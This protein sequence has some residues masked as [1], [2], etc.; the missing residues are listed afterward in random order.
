MRYYEIHRHDEFSLF[1]GFGNSKQATKYSKELGHKLLGLTNHGNIV[2]L[3]KHFKS[4]VDNDI[5]PILGCEF[6]FQPKIDKEEP[7]YHLC[8]FAKNLEGWENLCTLITISNQDDHFY[9]Q[10]RICFEDLEKYSKGLIVST[11]CISGYIP[12]LLSAGNEE[13]AYEELIKFKKIFKNDSDFYFEVQPILINDETQNKNG[14]DIQIYVNNELFKLRKKYMRNNKNKNIPVIVTTDAHF[15]SKEQFKSYLKMHEIK[16]TNIGEHYKERYIHSDIEIE[17]KLKK[18]HNNE[19]STIDNG[20]RLFQQTI[21]DTKEWFK[22]DLEI[23]QYRINKKFDNAFDELKYKCIKGLKEKGKTSKKY[24]ERLKH[25]LSVI[26][27][28]GF[29]DYFLIVAEYVNWAKENDIAV[30]PGRGSAGNSIITYALDITEVDAIYFNNNFDRFMRY[31]KKKFP[32]VDVDFCQTRRNEVINHILERYKNRSSQTLT[33]GYYNIKNLM[34]DL[35]KVCG[36]DDKAT[37]E[38]IKKEL[39]KY[40]DDNE[41]IINEEIDSNKYLSTVNEEYDNII[42]HFKNMYGKVR[43]FGTHASSVIVSNE[44]ISKKCG[45]M[46]IGSNIRTSFDLKDIE[47]LGL[48]KLDILG[49]SSASKAHELEKLTG[50]SFSY[51]MLNDYDTLK[52]FEKGN[53]SVFQFE[54]KSAND[55]AQEIGI[56]SFEDVI[57]ATSVNRPGP[58][59]LGMH[60][61]YKNNKLNPDKS[62]PIYE[63]TKETYGTLIYQEQGMPICREIGNLDWTITDKIVKADINHISKENLEEWKKAFIKGAKEYGLTKQQTKEIFTSLVQYSFNRGHGVAYSMLS[64]ELMYFKVHYPL[65]FWFCTMKY[66]NKDD[67]LIKHE[68]Q[69]AKEGII[70]LLPHVNGKSDYSITKLDGE[71]CIQRGLTTIKGVGEK[72]ALSIEEE[73][74]ANGKFKS[75]RDFTDRM[76]GNRSVTSRVIETL[77]KEGALEFN[78]KKY[79]NR[80][81]RYNVSLFQR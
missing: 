20:M 41:H 49:L 59:S 81:E 65:Q 61:K 63:Y 33:Y 29:E 19:L 70:I 69:A 42:T 72:A 35:Y 27:Y 62:S 47:F 21:G 31:D 5:I 64:A 32:D 51:D 78:S 9:R 46:R 80:I 45:L 1:D 23:P 43:Y 58:L 79:L 24:K 77:I 40:C 3:I 4:C 22:F 71:R 36:V 18:Y 10:N 73:H 55:I 30:G 53:C 28:H 39:E 76:K 15:I 56:D 11:A 37:Q 25:E 52:G 68:A 57:V 50:I 60:T 66:E 13:L 74:K 14:E 34:N 38:K 12:S 7:Y 17:R 75:V 8:V 67:N 16:S 44:N 6:Y 2:G 26:K 54:S 48:L